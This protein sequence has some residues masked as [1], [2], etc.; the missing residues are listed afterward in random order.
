VGKPS[1]N[2][3]AVLIEHNG[4][5][6]RAARVG[7]GPLVTVWVQENGNGGRGMI[8]DFDQTVEFIDALNDLLDEIENEQK[9]LDT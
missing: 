7:K 5:S 8:L 4:F 1:T 9:G 2:N 3:C 6:I